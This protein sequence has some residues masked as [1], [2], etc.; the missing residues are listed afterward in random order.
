[1]TMADDV[2]TL[3]PDLGLNSDAYAGIVRVL[4]KLLANEHVMYMKLRKYHWNVTG[5]QF[6]QLHEAFE[7]FYT[8]LSE[9]IDTTAEKIR[10]YGH[11]APGTLQEMI[12][13]SDMTEEPGVNPDAR[14]M[15]MNLMADMEAMVRFLREAV[16]E[17]D[18]EYDDEAA[19]DY[20]TGLMHTYQK[21]AWMTRAFLEG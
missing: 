13:L 6:F 3:Q 1:M 5:M 17:V 11:M 4:S 10:E 15:T 8:A 2:K 12:E 19:E 21:Q 7:E 9:E 16:E 18:E 20:L 14:T